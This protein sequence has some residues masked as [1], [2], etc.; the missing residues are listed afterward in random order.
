MKFILNHLQD[1]VNSTDILPA[2]STDHSLLLFSI[3]NDKS[4]KNG[5]GFWKFNNDL[6]YGAVYVENMK[7]IITKINNS[8]EVNRNFQNTKF[9]NPLLLKNHC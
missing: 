1:F 4:D 3:L 7:K 5:N 6:V 9:E 8:N 2:L